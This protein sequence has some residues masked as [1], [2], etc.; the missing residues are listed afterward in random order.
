MN[1]QTNP[2]LTI[3]QKQLIFLFYFWGLTQALAQGV[4]PTSDVPRHCRNC[5]PCDCCDTTRLVPVKH[6]REVRYQL[7]F[8]SPTMMPLRVTELLP[9]VEGGTVKQLGRATAP[10]VQLWGFEVNLPRF[11]VGTD[12]H[13]ALPTRHSGDMTPGRVELHTQSNV[14]FGLK[15]GVNLLMT[16]RSRVY[17]QAKA[18]FNHLTLRLDRS[19]N[20]LGSG[21][22][23]R[24]L[25]QQ[26]ETIEYTELVEAMIGTDLWENNLHI[27]QAFY[28]S[29]VGAGYD[30]RLGKF[31]RVGA[32]VGY[33]HQLG[34]RGVWWLNY[35]YH[36][37]DES[38]YRIA[39]VP[40]RADLSGFTASITLGYVF[41]R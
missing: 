11:F 21:S 37:E 32:Y 38:Q 7:S 18:D 31:F 14:Q 6:W 17:V 41:A 3:M 33:V 28:T 34:Q 24:F 30:Y 40:V 29:Q 5:H 10:A 15:T 35:E 23:N 8:L 4:L 19:I 22:W 27:R 1:L 16:A 25:W 9:N 26:G 13:W 2:T 12:A 39:N 36:P 20:D